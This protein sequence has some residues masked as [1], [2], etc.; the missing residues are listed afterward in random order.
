M[1]PSPIRSQLLAA[2]T[3]HG[4]MTAAEL[5]EVCR[6]ERHQVNGAI[7]KA[8]A[9]ALHISA[10][11][12]QDPGARGAM[13]PVYAPGPGTYAP[14]PRPRSSRERNA[15]YRERNRAE[16]RIKGRVTYAAEKPRITPLSDLVHF[17]TNT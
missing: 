7:L 14:M 15:A 17:A 11:R 13:A 1:K 4:P 10:W 9:S 12:R 2:L 3:Q 5:A 16:L 6:L 8:P